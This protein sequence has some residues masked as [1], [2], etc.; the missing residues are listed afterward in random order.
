MGNEVSLLAA[1]LSVDQCVS[2]VQV[3]YS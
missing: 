2:S 1:S 3:L